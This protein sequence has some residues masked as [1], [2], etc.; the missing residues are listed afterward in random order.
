MTV[1]RVLSFLVAL[2]IRSNWEGKGGCII[3]ISLG[4]SFFGLPLK[5]VIHH[6]GLVG[7]AVWSGR[8]FASVVS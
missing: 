7:D 5:R 2:G 6:E 1:F 4:A 8:A 3:W